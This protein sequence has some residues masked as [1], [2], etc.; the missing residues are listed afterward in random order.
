MYERKKTLFL[1]AFINIFFSV[2][3]R[4][5]KALKNNWKN[6]EQKLFILKFSKV[7]YVSTKLSLLKV[8][9]AL[10]LKAYTNFL[11][12]YFA[13][14][15]NKVT[16]ACRKLYISLEKKKTQKLLRKL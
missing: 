2:L 3:R 14:D 7:Y 8:L 13:K 16:K 10:H 9:E 4:I 11:K 5:T 15:K 6:N 12:K 1:E